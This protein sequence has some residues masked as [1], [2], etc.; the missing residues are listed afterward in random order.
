MLFNSLAFSL[1]PLVR[2]EIIG[3]RACAA[4]GNEFHIL[5]EHTG[6]VAR[7][8]RFPLRSARGQFMRCD[9]KIEAARGSVN[10][11]FVTFANEGDASA[12]G[13]LGRNVAHDHPVTATGKAA[14]GYQR[15]RIAEAGSN[16]R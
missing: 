13:C 2:G 16:Q 15:Y 8:G 9:V 5:S 7:I 10:R 1:P 11:D 14:V 6:A 4:A 3:D 12:Y